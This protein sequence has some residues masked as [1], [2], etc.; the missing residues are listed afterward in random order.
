MK[1]GTA[2][3]CQLQFIDDGTHQQKGWWWKIHEPGESLTVSA[4][5][6]RDRRGRESETEELERS[7]SHIGL[8]PSAFHLMRMLYR[9]R[10]L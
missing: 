3:K 2:A 9:G 7:I 1:R 8:G 4:R 10:K 5:Y 6:Q